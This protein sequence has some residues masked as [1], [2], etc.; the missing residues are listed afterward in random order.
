MLRTK[1]SEIMTAKDRYPFFSLA[2][3]LLG[4]SVMYKAAMH[5][6]QGLYRQGVLATFQ[7]PCPVI[8]VGNLTVGG[9]GKTPMVIY[10]AELCR[11]IGYRP[12][13]LSR[14]Y[15]SLA[16]HSG[17]V[18]SDERAVLCDPRYAGDE[19]FLM[20]ALLPG[21]PVMVGGN[22]L[23]A[24]RKAVARFRPDVILLDDA[25]QHVRLWR[26]LNILMMDAKYPFG[27]GYLLPRGRLREPA[28]SFRR[29]DAVILT[30]ADQ[31]DAQACSTLT[32]R[33]GPRPVFTCRH[34]TIV[35]KKLRA[36]RPF[37]SGL[38][39]AGDPAVDF[40]RNGAFV[41]SGLG[42]NDAFFHALRGCG[43]K[44][45]GQISFEDHHAYSRQDLNR[46]SEAATKAGA[47]LLITSDKDF[48]RLPHD[49]RF[50]RD[51][52]IMGV[53]L[54]FGQQAGKVQAFFSRRLQ[55]LIER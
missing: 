15:K 51:L 30:R 26:D 31:L 48:V 55:G 36:G 35:R 3:L 34:A 20:A 24:G 53:N 22:R 5:L 39:L 13:I 17:A 32:R 54:D 52:V 1:V 25:Y 44:L 11:A 4:G 42:C 49:G 7:L 9:T 38:D 27:N 6:R 8:A 28:G 19:P 45:L 2:T 41:F 47:G 16:E 50:S 14:G 18:V 33:V 46:I 29:A 43:V 21:V 40:K 10:L 23:A 37:D 12:V